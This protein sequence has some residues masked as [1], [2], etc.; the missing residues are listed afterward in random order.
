MPQGV[1]RV[2]QQ[3]H[4]HLLETGWVAPS[5]GQGSRIEICLQRDLIHSELIGDQIDRVAR[6]RVEIGRAAV[7]RSSIRTKRSRPESSL[8]ARRGLS[9]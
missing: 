1:N 3:I 8:P 7:R 4:Q 5:R 6:H 9:G 2:A